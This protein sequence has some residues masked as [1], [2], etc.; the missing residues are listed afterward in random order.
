MVA[1]IG[2]VYACGDQSETTNPVR[3]VAA[4]V[5]GDA[6]NLLVLDDGSGMVHAEPAPAMLRV[7]AAPPA[8]GKTP[9]K[10]GQHR[11][12]RDPMQEVLDRVAK[13]PPQEL[14]QLT[15]T[16]QEPP[17]D[18]EQFA[19]LREDEPARA[20]FVDNRRAQLDVLQE[21]LLS[22]L[23]A[24]GLKG[25]GLW[26]V[27]QVQ[28]T[29]P[30]SLVPDVAA[31]PKVIGIS[32][33]AK[34]IPG[35]EWD[36]SHSKDGTMLTSFRL[37]GLD[38]RSGNRS[39]SGSIRI[40]IMEAAMFNRNHAGWDDWH[41]GPSRIQAVKTCNQYGC[42]S[43]PTTG[44]GQTVPAQDNHGTL[45]TWVAAGSIE[46]HQDPAFP[47][48]YTLDQRRRSGHLPEAEIYFYS[49]PGSQ[50]IRGAIDEAVLDGVD[51]LNLSLRWMGQCDNTWNVSGINEALAAAL[52]AGV[53]V[54][55]CGGNL[56][57]GESQDDC[58]VWY[59]GLRTE[60]LAVNGLDTSSTWD[61]YH[62]LDILPN[63]CRGGVTVRSWGSFV[64]GYTGAIDLCAPGT[65]RL[66]FSHPDFTDYVSNV[67]ASGCSVASPVV[68]AVAGALRNG[69]H[70][71]GWPTTSAKVLMVNM[72]LMGDGW[73]AD[74]GG[75]N[76][77][78]MS[79]LSGAGR[80][81]MHWAGP[82]R[83]VGLGCPRDPD[84]DWRL[85]VVDRG[86][87]RPGERFR[88]AVEVGRPLVRAGSAG[89]G[90]HRLLCVRHLPPGRR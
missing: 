72:L 67:A 51:I 4:A 10:V 3:K 21:P 77:S 9:P 18:W 43:L 39:T 12:M 79:D 62:N 70:S 15:V 23:E 89:R 32:L 14:V 28:T 17:V 22:W 86:G 50:A 24:K 68:A 90:R 76:E 37:A 64:T 31:F 52:N 7:G 65:L 40:G 47:S 84:D 34:T 53:L 13:L 60:T 25:R 44:P 54:A 33:A 27:N 49:G 66:Y 42:T 81:R 2:I 63:A 61:P 82:H 45:V 80:V 69:F 26:L 58:H 36:G 83:S 57:P 88:A 56:E 11:P 85:C 87:C 29:V 73:D 6:H 55:A 75:E 74:S 1:S 71:I 46:Q 41:N 38:G 5:E 8:F 20:D 78:R 59:P 19:E 16:L 48:S 30:A 35:V